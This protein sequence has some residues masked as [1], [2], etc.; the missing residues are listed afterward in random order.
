MEFACGF[1]HVDFACG[2]LRVDFTFGFCVWILR[3][4]LGVYSLGVYSL[5]LP[6]LDLAG[7]SPVW[8]STVWESTVW[9]STV[10]G[11]RFGILRATYLSLKKRYRGPFNLK[12]V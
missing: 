5:G 10:S 8:D 2:F 12:V 11:Y 6:I 3:L 7:H 1:L 4:D 9:E